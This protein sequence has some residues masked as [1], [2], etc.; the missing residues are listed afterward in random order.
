MTINS[1][2]LVDECKPFMKPVHTLSVCLKSY[3][4]F[5]GACLNL[6]KNMKCWVVIEDNKTVENII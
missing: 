5:I 1:Y 2:C 4:C 6:I 3:I